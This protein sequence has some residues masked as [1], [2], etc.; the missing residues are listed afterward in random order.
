MC[1]KTVVYI[2]N[3]V[4]PDQMPH[5]VASDLGLF[6]QACLSEYLENIIYEPVHDKTY[7]KD[8]SD[9]QRL[10]SACTSAQYGRV[11]CSSFFLMN[12]RL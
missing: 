9:Q 6:A 4:N 5:S 2:G 8:P 11:S 7:N 3:S 10:R 12:L 1:L